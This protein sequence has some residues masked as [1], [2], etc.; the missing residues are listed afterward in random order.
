MKGNE[1]DEE[2][3]SLDETKACNDVLIPQVVF[4]LEKLKQNGFG[5]W[6]RLLE[7]ASTGDRI[8]KHMSESM[9]FDLKLLYSLAII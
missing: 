2:C 3:T 6:K 7:V 5:R 1:K 8:I 4:N 9:G